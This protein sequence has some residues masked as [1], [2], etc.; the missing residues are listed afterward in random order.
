MCFC[1]L[2]FVISD[3]QL[4]LRSAK[5]RSQMTSRLLAFDRSTKNIS[6][7]QTMRI[8]SAHAA[9]SQWRSEE[10]DVSPVTSSR[11][12]RG[13]RARRN[14]QRQIASAERHM[15]PCVVGTRR[16]TSPLRALPGLAYRA[17]STDRAARALLL[18]RSC[19]AEGLS[20]GVHCCAPV[21]CDVM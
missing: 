11:R 18:R 3:D 12:C 4:Q 13:N 6:N 21:R 5:S 20:G 10:E 2:N 1:S 16:W 7:K 15:V 9:A 17:D 14:T 8:S 19:R